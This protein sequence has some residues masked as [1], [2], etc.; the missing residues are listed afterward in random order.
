MLSRQ[1]RSF[2]AAA[3][4]LLLAS[5]T[6]LAE[7][8]SVDLSGWSA[9]GTGV[10]NGWSLTSISSYSD[11]AVRF[12]SKESEAVS[13]FFR[14]AIV[15][16]RAAIKCS[17]EATRFL[18]FAGVDENGV[19]LVTNRAAQASSSETCREQ[20]FRYDPA[21]DVRRLRIFFTDI[22]SGS[23]SKW[24]F[25][26]LAIVFDDA[27]ER[28]YPPTALRTTHTNGW[29]FVGE[30]TESDGAVSNLV[31]VYRL[32]TAPASCTTNETFSFPT[33]KSNR[34]QAYD[35]TDKIPSRFPGFGGTYLYEPTNTALGLQ[36]GARD[37][38]GL[39]TYAGKGDY[40]GLS[41]CLRLSRPDS[42]D[43]GRVMPLYW[44][45]DA[46]T[47]DL[48]V[49]TI[50]AEPADYFVSLDGVPGGAMLAVSSTTNLVKSGRVFVE[51]MSFVS[52]YAPEHAV[53]NFVARDLPAVGGRVYTRGLER[54]TEYFWSVSALS[55]SGIRSLPS[56][57]ASFTTTD[58]EPPGMTVRIR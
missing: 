40:T 32:S 1:N 51:G 20:V 13:P 29:S 44:I 24:G 37:K 16:V 57:V 34:Q 53:T 28:I 41:L 22:A 18:A 17:N 4:V 58:E 11:G 48:D 27:T 50:A 43:D 39:L 45:A 52:D 23:Q 54:S 55:A 2:I 6:A 56:E 33:E 10:T 5:A 35:V 9:V 19:V 14:K 21:L 7:T 3:V 8:A 31:N 25:N 42:K 36:I 12:N 46:S 15:E 49:L 26:S 47:N 38:P 30:W